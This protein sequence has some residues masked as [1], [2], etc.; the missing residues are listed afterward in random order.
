MSASDT[1]AVDP[2]AGS[3]KTRTN[4]LSAAGGDETRT[5]VLSSSSDAASTDADA[6]PEISAPVTLIGIGDDGCA[7][8]SSRA[9]HAVSRAQVLAGGERLLEFFPQFEGQRIVL[10]S[11]IKQALSEIAGLADENNVCVLASGDPLFFGVGGLLI[12]TI[13]AGRVHVIPHPSSVQLAF[14]RAGLKWDDAAWL[15]LHGRDRAGLLTKLKRLAKVALLTDATNS[16]PAIARYLLDFGESDWHAVVGERLGGP[17]ERVRRF[18][19]LEELA[20]CTDIDELNVLIL[21]RSDPS[22]RPAPVLVNLSEDEYAKRV[23]K[24]GLIT[25]KEVRLLSIGALELRSDSVIWD[26]GAASGSIAIESALLAVQGRAFAIEVEAESLEFCRENLKNLAVDNITVVEGRAPEILESIERKFDPDAVFIGGSKGSLREIIAVC[27]ER[28]RPGGRMVVN[29]ITFE[30]IQE[31][32]ATARD[33][34]LDCDITQV[35]IS[36][37]VPIARF[38]RYD[39]Q[40]PIHIFTIRKSEE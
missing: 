26:V 37:A 7:S 6:A 25:K 14:A 35:Q 12:Q 34:E 3:P 9:V 36:R 38:H 18:E 15:S 24:K 11:G 2:G 21:L 30:N 29:A 31:A 10:K 5:N 20:G 8:L 16:P 28:L 17:G 33:M 22:W 27:Y 23:P 32:Y 13:G 1:N 19:S 4:V 40:N 39:A